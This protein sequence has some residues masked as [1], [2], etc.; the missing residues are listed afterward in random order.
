VKNLSSVETIYNSLKDLLSTPC[1]PFS[2]P[3]GSSVVF[4][5]LLVLQKLEVYW[6]CLLEV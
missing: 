3:S 1:T 4:V 2:L 6:L 5:Y